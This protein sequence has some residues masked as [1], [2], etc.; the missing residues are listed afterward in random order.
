MNQVQLQADGSLKTE[1]RSTA[2]D[3]FAL[4]GHQIVLD[5]ACTLRSFFLLLEHYPELM[6]LSAFLQ[7]LLVQYRQCPDN[8]CRW[9]AF[10]ALELAKTVEMVGYPGVPRLDIYNALKGCD[11]QT[12][13]RPVEIRSLALAH[14]LD[15]P[16]RLGPLN[17]V[18]F[19]DR[20]DDFTYNTV[21]TLFEFI[22]SIAWALSFHGTPE[23]CQIRS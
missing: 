3:P 17:H 8:G 20:M 2:L 7:G 16:L 19:G 22:D 9:D 11:P 14:L 4:L 23:Q 1:G 12:P 18:V 15:L 6:R 5:D 10:E 21:Y 13:D